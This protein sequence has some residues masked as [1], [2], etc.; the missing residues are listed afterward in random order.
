MKTILNHFN[1]RT[2]CFAIKKGSRYLAE[3][4]TKLTLLEKPSQAAAFASH[5]AAV[6][7]AKS[8]SAENCANARLIGAKV[9]VAPFYFSKR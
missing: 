5:E 2:D 9:A 7:F 1:D 3:D 6:E 4:G 8:A